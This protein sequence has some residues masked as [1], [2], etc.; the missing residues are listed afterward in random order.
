MTE[1]ERFTGAYIQAMQFSEFGHDG[2]IPE[3]AELSDNAMLDIEADCRSFWRRF[4]CYVVTDVCRAAF[5][6][7][8]SKA[9]HDFY[10]TRNGH[11]VGFWETEWPE[12]YR[13]ILTKAAHGY[14]E[15]TAY[16]GDDN[17]VYI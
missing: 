11:G 10:F 16:V 2:D 15:T 14:G 13:D 7:P 17:L 6:D 3:D 12:S 5:D 9:G 1:L 4:G 8:V